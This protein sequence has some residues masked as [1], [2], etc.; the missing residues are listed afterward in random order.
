MIS[1]I[2]VYRLLW[3]HIENDFECLQTLEQEGRVRCLCLFPNNILVCG[4]WNGN[5]SLFTSTNMFYENK[6]GKNCKTL[7]FFKLQENQ[8]VIT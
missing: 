1:L 6:V 8:N 2:K 5:L 7:I 3:A 4:L